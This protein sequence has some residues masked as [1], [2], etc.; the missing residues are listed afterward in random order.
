M[1]RRHGGIPCGVVED[2]HCGNSKSVPRRLVALR[3]QERCASNGRDAVPLWSGGCLEKENEQRKGHCQE[4][5]HTMDE[6]GRKGR[7]VWNGNGMAKSKLANKAGN[8]DALQP[9][10]S[11]SRAVS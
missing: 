8:R 6:E 10:E 3:R 7:R 1:R 2:G 9:A 4:H 5:T 11:A